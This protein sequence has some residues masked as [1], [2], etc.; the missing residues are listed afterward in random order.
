MGMIPGIIIGLAVLAAVVLFYGAS[1]W[2]RA[3]R[4]M[5]GDLEAGRHAAGTYRVDQLVPAGAS[6][7]TSKPSFGT[8]SPSSPP[9]I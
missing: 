3:T 6:V 1:R 9:S 2:Q 4:R 7:N 5:R 8:V